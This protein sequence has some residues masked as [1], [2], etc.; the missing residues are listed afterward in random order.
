M[1]RFR[2]LLKNLAEFEDMTD[3]GEFNMRFDVSEAILRYMEQNNL[4]QVKMAE[5]LGIKTP[6]LN[7]I[8]HAKQNLQIDAIVRIGYKLGLRPRIMMEP[9][10][11]RQNVNEW[12]G[13][14]TLKLSEG[15]TSAQEN[16]A[17]WTTET[18]ARPAAAL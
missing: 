18:T 3:G 8:I 7:K 11:I 13:M 1:S 15:S 17:K 2:V 10:A 9:A 14:Q 4:T 16:K 5:I 12:T 6:R